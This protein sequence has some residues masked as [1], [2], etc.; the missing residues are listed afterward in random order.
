MRAAL[1]LLFVVAALLALPPRTAHATP[2]RDACTGVVHQDAAEPWRTVGLTTPG[3]WCLDQDLVVDATPSSDV[4][5]VV[6]AADAVTL[7]CRGYAMRLSP[8]VQVSDSIAVYS[9]NRASVAVRNCRFEGFA[10]A[11]ELFDSTDYLIEDNVVRDGTG[12]FAGMGRAIH[13]TGSGTIRR[14]RLDHAVGKGIQ[15]GGSALVADN[16]IDHLAEGLEPIQLIG[17][18]AFG[19]DFEIRG[20]TIR[21]MLSASVTGI[22]VELIAGGRA[23][24]EDNVLVQSEPADYRTALRCWQPPVQYADNVISG[25]DPVMAECTDA[26][27]NDASP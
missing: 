1:A 25:F 11:I 2:G 10:S 20:N 12:D 8:D 4:L 15:V 9:S 6:V 17:I 13:A 24:V 5:L 7:D 21:D 3:T 16:V 19:G 27:D 22:D 23:R 26:G 18:D 14:N